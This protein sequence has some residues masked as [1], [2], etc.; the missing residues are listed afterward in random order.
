[1]PYVESRVES[2]VAEKEEL[3]IAPL[4]ATET[5]IVA[6]VREDVLECMRELHRTKRYMATNTL[7]YPALIKVNDDGNKEN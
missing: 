4:I 3:Y 2:I 5:E 6:N 1:M 7:N